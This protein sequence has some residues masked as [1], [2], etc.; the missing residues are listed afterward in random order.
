MFA[1][2]NYIAEYDLTLFLASYPLFP[3]EEDPLY[4]FMNTCVST[5]ETWMYTQA[6]YGTSFYEIPHGIAHLSLK[7]NQNEELCIPPFIELLLVMLGDQ[8]RDYF[9]LR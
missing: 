5:M 3:P 6:F 1:P 7:Q 9:Q 8:A 2:K 4:A